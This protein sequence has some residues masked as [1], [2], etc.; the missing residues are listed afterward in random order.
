M[1]TIYFDPKESYKMKIQSEYKDNLIQIGVIGSFFIGLWILIIFQTI[2]ANQ[3]PSFMLFWV[4]VLII[5]AI[6][7]IVPNTRLTMDLENNLW[8]LQRLFLF[9]PFSQFK[10]KISGIKQ[11]LI[12]DQIDLKSSKS[13]LSMERK[14][15]TSS[16]QIQLY[17]ESEKIEE[18]LFLFRKKTF[19]SAAHERNLDMITQMGIKMRKIFSQYEIPFDLEYNQK[20]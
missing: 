2:R 7:F 11:Y 13:K 17:P 3:F 19:D 14:E 5:I 10:G 18:N 4:V 6:Y 9:I 1:V 20:N 8:T 16:F 12:N 15:Y